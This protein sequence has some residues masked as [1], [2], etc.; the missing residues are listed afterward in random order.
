[1]DENEVRI[2]FNRLLDETLEQVG[3]EEDLNTLLTQLYATLDSIRFDVYAGQVTT[4]GKVGLL[5]TLI[6]NVIIKFLHLEYL[7]L[8]TFAKQVNL[9]PDTVRRK[10]NAGELLG[11]KVRNK[12][13]VR[14]SELWHFPEY[15]EGEEGEEETGEE[16]E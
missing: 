6:T 4:F 3:I 14:R 9:K 11:L 1:M 16:E 12:W 15:L 2:M 10:L 13:Y 7:P 5:K 8:E